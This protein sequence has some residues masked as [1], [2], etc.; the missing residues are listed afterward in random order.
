MVPT[1]FKNINFKAEVLW[2]VLPQNCFLFAKK[3][4][5]FSKFIKEKNV[6]VSFQLLPLEISFKA[7]SAVEA[8]FLGSLRYFRHQYQLHSIIYVALATLAIWPLWPY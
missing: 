7:K 5:G 4:K 2:E 1:D 6:L 8:A 3:Y